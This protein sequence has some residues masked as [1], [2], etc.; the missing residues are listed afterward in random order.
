MFNN[1]KMKLLIGGKDRN[2]YMRKDGSAYYKSGGQQVDVT[3]MFKKNGG[4]LKKQYIGGVQDNLGKVEQKKRSNKSA[5]QILGGADES[6]ILFDPIKVESE[7]LVNKDE[8]INNEEAKVELQKLC[9]IALNGLSIK[10][11]QLEQNSDKDKVKI[12]IATLEE[13]INY[14]DNNITEDT[15]NAIYSG[16]NV[17]HSTK[18]K[19]DFNKEDSERSELRKLGFTT[20]EHSVT[21]TRA[22]ILNKILLC[23][24]EDL[25][26]KDL[27]SSS[28][29]DDIATKRSVHTVGVLKNKPFIINPQTGKFN[30]DAKT[31]KEILNN[32]VNVLTICME[33]LVDQPKLH[34]RVRNL[35]TIL[36]QHEKIG[37][38]AVANIKKKGEEE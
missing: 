9:Y 22:Y 11:N 20:I 6:D 26:T 10:S 15:K 30:A 14:V 4:G 33:E 35:H 23:F 37:A 29:D 21:V 12:S 28:D 25:A 17:D 36:F 18:L 27:T 16:N 8:S 24:T 31:E 7:K 19:E 5:K 3:H 13:F 34:T 32:I 2:I 38:P 1:I